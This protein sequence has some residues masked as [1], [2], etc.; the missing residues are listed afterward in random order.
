MWVSHT[1]PPPHRTCDERVHVRTC[2]CWNT[3]HPSSA[4]SLIMVRSHALTMER[5]IAL[6]ACEGCSTRA[7]PAS[8]ILCGAFFDP[9]PSAV[10]THAIFY[11]GLQPWSGWAWTFPST[12]VLQRILLHARTDE[13][14][15]TD[16]V[17][18]TAIDE[19][20]VHCGPCC[21]CCCCLKD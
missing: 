2:V 13:V 19:P 17:A 11:C 14:Q 9:V 3:R 18:K 8:C 10:E 21:C 12:A 16:L 15:E 5:H 7:C 4:T 20:G 6:G 1:T